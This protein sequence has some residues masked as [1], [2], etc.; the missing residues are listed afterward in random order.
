MLRLAIVEDDAAY[1]NELKKYLLQYEKEKGEKFQINEFSDGDGI[2]Q[3]YK[4]D[5]DIILMDVE[6]AFVD[7]MT[8]ALEI[9][10]V[11]TDVVIIFIT[12]MPQY[13]IR[14]YTVD[15]LD[16]IL[17]P[18]S[19]YAFSE[20]ITRAL[21]RKQKRQRKFVVINIHGGMQKIDTE[22]I[23]YIEVMNHDL[24]FHTVDGDIT[25]KGTIRDIEEKLND[26]SF[27][28]CNKSFLINLSFV[29]G[30][31][32]SDINIGKDVVPV[33][34]AKKKPLMDALNSFLSGG[35]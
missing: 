10:K 4:S 5:Y 35:R 9:R 32:N 15:A 14:G 1:R 16:Y 34:R 17:K 25:T 7:G 30:V 18:I 26:S 31:V 8:A 28:Q 11:D 19:Y 22:R 6:M 20:T 29:D 3:N 2:L 23:R 33:S 27:F 13:A 21:G 12:N 24:I